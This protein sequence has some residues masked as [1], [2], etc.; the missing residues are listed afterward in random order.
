MSPERQRIAIAEHLFPQFPIEKIDGV[1]RHR[2]PDGRTGPVFNYLNDLNAMHEAV[3]TLKRNQRLNLSQHLRNIV[4]RA[5]ALNEPLF[6][7]DITASCENATAVQRAEAFLR[8]IGKWVTTNPTTDR[9]K[10]TQVIEVS[11]EQAVNKSDS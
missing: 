6:H 9:Q 1:L 4:V 10:S 8:T 2:Y 11:T 7:E 3:G 5:M